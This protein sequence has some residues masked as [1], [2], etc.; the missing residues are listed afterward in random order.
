MTS[1]VIGDRDCIP[2]QMFTGLACSRIVPIEEASQQ[3]EAF[4]CSLLKGSFS[5][6]VQPAAEIAGKHCSVREPL[7]HPGARPS[8]RGV[9]DRPQLAATTAVI[10]WHQPVDPVVR[11]RVAAVT[12][13]AL[14]AAVP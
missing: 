8:S 11:L 13:V 4:Y 9:Q 2:R 1:G 7:L 14:L 6:R 12:S 10:P 3:G 5:N